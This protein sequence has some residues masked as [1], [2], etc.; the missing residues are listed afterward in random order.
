MWEK[1]EVYAAELEES[2]LACEVNP[3]DKEIQC[4]DLVE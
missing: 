4:Y 2:K 3:L 1:E